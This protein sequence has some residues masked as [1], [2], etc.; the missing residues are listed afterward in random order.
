[1]GG[2]VASLLISSPSLPISVHL[3]PVHL[4]L[5]LP[6]PLSQIL[7]IPDL[8]STVPPISHQRSQLGP[9]AESPKRTAPS[10]GI[11]TGERFS[12]ARFISHEHS[13]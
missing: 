8:R 6:F 2:W 3:I 11:G 9:Q 10:I 5:C 7:P 12:D 1:M 4:N 13:K